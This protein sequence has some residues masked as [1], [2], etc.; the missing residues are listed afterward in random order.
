[1]LVS[2]QSA[3]GEE[4]EIVFQFERCGYWQSSVCAAACIWYAVPCFVNLDSVTHRLTHDEQ[5]LKYE[6]CH[7]SVVSMI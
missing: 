1:M 5:I 4:A 3:C 7:L 2:K 6:L